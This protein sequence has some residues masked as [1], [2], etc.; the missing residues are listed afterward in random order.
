MDLFHAQAGVGRNESGVDAGAEQV[1]GNFH[2]GG[3]FP[4]RFPFSFP[5]SPA[6]RKAFM[7]AFGLS[8]SF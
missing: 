5:F 2:F 6:Y 4:F 3:D 8:F 7:H 1:A